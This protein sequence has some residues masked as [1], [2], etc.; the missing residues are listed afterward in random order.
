MSRNLVA[1][2]SFFLFRKY[3]V[4]DSSSGVRNG[5]FR[6]SG[7][8]MLVENYDIFEEKCD[9]T[10]IPNA[11]SELFQLIS[12]FLLYLTAW[13]Y[14]VGANGFCYFVVR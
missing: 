1:S 9:V 2:R 11:M 8:V 3:F 14:L 13:V 5:N 4:E 12:G 6:L 10:E 7:S